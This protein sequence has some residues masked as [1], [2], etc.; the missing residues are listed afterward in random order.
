M[1]GS[2]DVE[3]VVR[4]HEEALDV[5]RETLTTGRV[6]VETVT[7]TRDEFVNEMVTTHEAQVERVPIGKFIDA[8]PPIHED[9]DVTVIPLIEEVLVI[10]RRL[11]LR[12]EIRIRRFATTKLHQ[13][14][15]ALRRQEAVIQREPTHDAGALPIPEQPDQGDHQ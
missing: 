15:V 11:F 10:E 7:S 1:A 3:N 9:G 12:E 2:P 14:T 6:R 5:S 8:A 13:E 4:L